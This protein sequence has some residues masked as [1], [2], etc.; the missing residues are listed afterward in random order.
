MEE[1]SEP[2]P[3]VRRAVKPR[4]DRYCLSEKEQHDYAAFV[5]MLSQLDKGA[6]LQLAESAIKEAAQPKPAAGA[7][8][9]GQALPQ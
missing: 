3:A 8:A 4:A 5:E 1:V 9:P 6:R 7:A 2:K